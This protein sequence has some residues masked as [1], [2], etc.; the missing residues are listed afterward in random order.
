MQIAGT[1]QKSLL[2]TEINKNSSKFFGCTKHGVSGLVFA[3]KKNGE[4]CF[5]ILCNH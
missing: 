2:Q 5:K 1:I 4:R 3:E